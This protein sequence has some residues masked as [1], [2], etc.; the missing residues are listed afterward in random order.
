MSEGLSQNKLK[1]MKQLF[2]TLN[3][4]AF[5]LN[6]YELHEKLPQFSIHE[7]KAFITNPEISDWINSE[8]SVLQR[9]V[10]Q[11]MLKNIENSKS[12][13]QAQ[14]IQALQKYLE[15]QVL[16]DNGPIFIYTYVPLSSEQEKAL[17][18]QKTDEDIFIP[19]QKILT[20]KF[21]P[22]RIIP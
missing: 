14:L 2:D 5:Y 1:E 7:W 11:K 6:H 10:L 12:T 9:K 18:V 15:T 21:A 4:D 13:G 16:N 20:S 19:G 8:L 17:N 22:E 3:T